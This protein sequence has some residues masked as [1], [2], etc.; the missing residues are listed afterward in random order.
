M[1]LFLLFS[2]ILFN[3]S[4]QTQKHFDSC[5]ESEFKGEKCEWVKKWCEQD[6]TE[7]ER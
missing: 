5:V 4:Y 7:C 3:G 1:I 6:F 2:A